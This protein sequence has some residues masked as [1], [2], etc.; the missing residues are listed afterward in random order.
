MAFEHRFLPKHGAPFTLLVL[1]GTGGDEHSLIPIAEAIAPHANLLSPRGKVLEDGMP[2]WFRRFEEGVF[3]ED[4][5]KRQAA[6][7]A[8]WLEEACSEYGVDPE[9]LYA[10]GYSNGA[11]IASSLLLLHPHAI[12][13]GVLLRAMV[14][15]NPNPL[16]DLRG[17]QVLIRNGRRDTMGPM[18]QTLAL[19][20]LYRSCGAAVE[21][22]LS[23]G[24]HNLTK[25]DIEVA[26]EW[27][28]RM[29]L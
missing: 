9:Q 6:D 26:A 18:E 7:L 24:G 3:D 4:D 14:P 23:D 25:E 20:Q 19:E 29:P 8:A 11:N 27:L 22:S 17:K 16:P 15:L 10:L 5:I 21:V 13:G 12:A 28:G 1:H 2:R